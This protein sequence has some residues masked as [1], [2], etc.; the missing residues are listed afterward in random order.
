MKSQIHV[1]FTNIFFGYNYYEES[2]LTV[3]TGIH[4]PHR[5]YRSNS[6]IMYT[7][8]VRS[9]VTRDQLHPLSVQTMDSSSTIAV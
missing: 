3:T 4:I 6:T 8:I 9:L 1:K 2:R 5:D 7:T